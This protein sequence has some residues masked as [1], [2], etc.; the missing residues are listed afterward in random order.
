M[1][2]INIDLDSRAYFKLTSV[3]LSDVNFVEYRRISDEIGL[4]S[5]RRDYETPVLSYL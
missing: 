4:L 5:K 2:C 3:S 1:L